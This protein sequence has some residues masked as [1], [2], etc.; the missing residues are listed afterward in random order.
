M[1][2]KCTIYFIYSISSRKA[3]ISKTIYVRHNCRGFI[4]VA[5]KGCG[6]NDIPSWLLCLAQFP[7]GELSIFAMCKI[8]IYFHAIIIHMHRLYKMHENYTSIVLCQRTVGSAFERVIQFCRTAIGVRQRALIWIVDNG[9]RWRRWRRIKARE[10][11]LNWFWI[12]KEIYFLYL[13][14]Y[15][16]GLSLF[17]L[18]HVFFSTDEF[19]LHV[20]V[21]CLHGRANFPQKKKNTQYV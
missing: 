9:R 5:D 1:R 20:T 11:E 2:S 7:N 3:R 14:L 13:H 21:N 18:L 15:E 4:H 10:R 19:N 12:K 6:L 16:P 8:L 17:A